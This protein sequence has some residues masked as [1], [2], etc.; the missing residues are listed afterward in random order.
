MEKMSKMQISLDELRSIP[1]VQRFIQASNPPKNR[2]IKLL[3]EYSSFYAVSPSNA[4]TTTSS[5]I[6]IGS[7]CSIF[8]PDDWTTPEPIS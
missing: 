5:K 7:S 2:Y 8:K 6:A 4:R 3:R 1:Q